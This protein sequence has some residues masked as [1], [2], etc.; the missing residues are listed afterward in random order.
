M[1]ST[2]LRVRPV[3]YN[4]P[5]HV[6]TGSEAENVAHFSSTVPLS[7]TSVTS[8]HGIEQEELRE[9]HIESFIKAEERGGVTLKGLIIP[10]PNVS[11]VEPPSYPSLWVQ[12]ACFVHHP[13]L[14]H[15]SI[16]YDL[17][18]EDHQFLSTLLNSYDINIPEDTFENCVESLESVAHH[19]SPFSTEPSS[20]VDFEQILEKLLPESLHVSSPLV[21]DYWKSKRRKIKAPVIPHLRP[22]PPPD[23]TSPLRPFRKIESVEK[24]KKKETA[25]IPS[26]VSTT[27]STSTTASLSAELVIIGV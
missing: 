12:P 4:K 22:V 27:G 11:I 14:P 15:D 7:V 6:V 24:K 1:A 3:D 26:S 9:V 21:V 2:S 13:L 10:V 8:V 18:E 20:L 5:L 17:D 23:D 25:V 19:H 16:V